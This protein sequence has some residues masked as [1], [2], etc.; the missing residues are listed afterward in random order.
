MFSAIHTKIINYFNNLLI[1]KTDN[2]LDEYLKEINTLNDD[3]IDVFLSSFTKQKTYY[4]IIIFNI[5][6]ILYAY[7]KNK[8]L[9]INNIYQLNIISYI[10]FI[11]IIIKDLI[12][13]KYNIK[14]IITNEYNQQNLIFLCIAIKK[15]DSFNKFENNKY[16]NIINYLCKILNIILFFN[17]NYSYIYFI[18]D[19]SIYR[20]HKKE[21]IDSLTSDN[22][23]KFKEIEIKH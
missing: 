17:N 2:L 1:N 19:I 3:N 6:R 7:Y 23:K 11:N 15:L 8:Y 10:Y 13:S 21:I 14:T 16:I 12:T 20:D 4:T 9:V 5:F 22:I 18:T